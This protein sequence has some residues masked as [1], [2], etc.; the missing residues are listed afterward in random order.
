MGLHG[1]AVDHLVSVHI[2]TAEGKSVDL[3]LASSG[4]EKAL[5]QVLRGAGFGYGVITSI[6]MKVYPLSRLGRK[7]DKF[8]IRRLIFP[9]PA[10]A[11][12]AE[13]FLSTEVVPPNMSL[14]LISARAPPT[15][16]KPGAPMAI[17]AATFFGSEEAAV[18]ESSISQLFE[19]AVVSKAV[20]AETATVPFVNINDANEPFNVHG[21]YKDIES[22]WTTK[23]SLDVIVSNYNRWLSFTSEH[24]DAKRSIVVTSRYNTTVSQTNAVAQDFVECRDRDTIFLLMTW[25][26]KQE[27]KEAVA[28]F[29]SDVKQ[30]ARQ[31][32]TST[33]AK[34]FANNVTPQTKLQELFSENSLN[35]IRK[36]K[37]VWDEH[38]LFW[39]P[40][41]RET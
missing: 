7:D 40:W 3:S 8:V 35:E 27:S 9:A 14:S 37:T 21:G 6:T 10:I 36:V 39:S 32:E 1:F 13:A 33:A 11:V 41:S 18:K 15:A 5:F 23:P 30:T 24:E 20:I 22:A 34:T 2:I 26:T 12:A 29:I 31:D 4:E 28:N 19:E 25:F 17:L 16:P 38:N